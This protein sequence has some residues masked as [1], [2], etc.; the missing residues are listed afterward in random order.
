MMLKV[1]IYRRLGPSDQFVIYSL[2]GRLRALGKDAAPHG[3]RVWDS[4]RIL[5]ATSAPWPMTY[6][7]P[8]GMLLVSDF[9]TVCVVA[10]VSGSHRF[11][12]HRDQR[13]IY[14]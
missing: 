2:A 10:T 3:M 11:A 4:A 1:M 13:R 6:D 14:G 7:L 8:A 12:T 9:N 5:Q